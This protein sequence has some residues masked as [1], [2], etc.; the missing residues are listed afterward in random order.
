MD[1][2]VVVD[3]F[4]DGG[5][6]SSGQEARWSF[7]LGELSF[8]V[9]FILRVR[10]VG[11]QGLFE[12]VHSNARFFD[13]MQVLQTG[14]DLVLDTELDHQLVDGSLLDLELDFLA[15]NGVPL[16]VFQVE[17]DGLY[18]LVWEFQTYLNNDD[19]SIIASLDR[20]GVGISSQTQGGFP[21]GQGLVFG[22]QL[23]VFS[24]GFLFAYGVAF[25]G[26]RDQVVVNRRVGHGAMVECGRGR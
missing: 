21:L 8:I 18:W 25:D 22:I 4:G 15:R 7:N 2:L 3:E 19:S 16:C 13:R 9:R 6:A 12:F 17:C 23:G 5:I 26:F 1:V 20:I 10:S 24:D 14:D 11:T